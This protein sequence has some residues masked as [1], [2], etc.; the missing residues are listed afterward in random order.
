MRA[1]ITGLLDDGLVRFTSP[2]GTANATWRGAEPPRAGWTHVELDFPAG[3]RTWAVVPDRVP[4]LRG[5]GDAVHVTARVAAYTPEDG[6]VTLELGDSVVLADLP[7]PA[8]EIRP[9]AWLRLTAAGLDLYP[10]DL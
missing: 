2:L 5:T 3:I 8:P 7:A 6:V 9:G 4:E 1:E 10:V